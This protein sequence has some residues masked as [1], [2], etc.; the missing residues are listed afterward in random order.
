VGNFA[1]PAAAPESGL[2]AV[3]QSS[4]N[5][6]MRF[7]RALELE[8]AGR[9]AESLELLLGLETEAS[10]SP[11]LLVHVGRAL[12]AA[13]RAAEAET[14]ISAALAH[15]PTSVELHVLLA[16]LLWQ[17]GAG[18]ASLQWLEAAIDAH[19]HELGLR[20]VAAGLLKNMDNAPRALELLE[21]GLARA[22]QSAAFLTSLGVVLDELDRPHEALGYLRAAIPRARNPA[23]AM[24]N[25]ASTLL[26]TGDAAEALEICEKLIA[27]TPDDQKLL[28][29]RA[30]ALRLLG[31]PRHAALCDHD[32]FVRTYRLVPPPPYADIAEF[33]AAFGRELEALHFSTQRP[34][35]QSLRGGTQTERRLPVENPVIAQFFAMLDA[36]IREYIA[37]LD[38]VDAA[39]PTVRRARG[40]YRI[41]GSWSVKLAPGGFHTN[42]VHPDG[43][44]SSAYYVAVPPV[45]GDSRAT[46]LKFGEPGVRVGLAPEHYVRPEAG[47]LVLFP[48]FF[49]HGTVPFHE[50]GGRLTAA[51]DVLPD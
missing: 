16:E 35:S 14:K 21:A 26:R 24:L 29:Y 6:Q 4:Q 7:A 30:T 28:A 47:L 9:A 1:T 48:S 50:G 32:R 13:N 39:H 25:L 41:G 18:A 10:D 27:A 38:P 17:R 19:P 11:E 37:R 22:P 44:L 46:W 8:R 23:P 2:I 36:P 51:F 15:W 43:W 31:D 5:R 3:Q 40:G 34:V 12:T 45:N 33:N 42:H 20:L 49:W